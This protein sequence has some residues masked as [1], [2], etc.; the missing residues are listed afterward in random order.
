MEG[1]WAVALYGIRG[2]YFC[3]YTCSDNFLDLFL[4]AKTASLATSLAAYWM[5][6]TL[7]SKCKNCC[8]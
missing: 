4:C 7:R 5:I 2:V 3:V 1:G 6:S 8:S